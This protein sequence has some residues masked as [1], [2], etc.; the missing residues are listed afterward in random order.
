MLSLAE[1]ANKTKSILVSTQKDFVRIPKSYRSLINTLEGEIF[2]ENEELIKEIL[3][4]VIE[5]HFEND[6]L[7]TLEIC[8]LI[9]GENQHIYDACYEHLINTA[10]LYPEN[11]TLIMDGL[12]I[13]S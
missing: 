6:W 12:K 3:T 9:K 5:N 8:E 2:F 1:T 7:L 13:I 10:K 4:N 11:E